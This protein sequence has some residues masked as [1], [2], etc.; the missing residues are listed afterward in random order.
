VTAPQLDQA[1][2]D[3]ISAAVIRAIIQASMCVGSDGKRT[4]VLMSGEIVDALWTIQAAL[5]ATSPSAA[6]P[7]ELRR[8]CDQHAKRLYRRTR[9][10]QANPDLRSV[11]SEIYTVDRTATN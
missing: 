9:L 1:Y 7:T 6:T 5:L 8:F 11:F 10:M 4:A 2:L 3:R